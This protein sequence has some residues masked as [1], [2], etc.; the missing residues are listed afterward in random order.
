MRPFRFAAA[1]MLTV[2]ACGPAPDE[3][4]DGPWPDRSPRHDV[5]EELRADLLRPRAEADGGGTATIEELG[6]RAVAGRPGSWRIVYRAGPLGVTVGG[7]VY[8]QVS[9]FWGWST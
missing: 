5:V 4:S 6:G 2:V 3:S 9:P 1:L 8:L 7:A